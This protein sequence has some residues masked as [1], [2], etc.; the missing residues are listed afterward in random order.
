M[1]KPL[2]II[3]EIYSDHDWNPNQNIM[4]LELAKKKSVLSDKEP[5]SDN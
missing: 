4:D 5:N 1:Y 3:L 2:F